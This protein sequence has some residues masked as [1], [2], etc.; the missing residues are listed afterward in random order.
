MK[1]ELLKFLV[2]LL[3]AIGAGPLSAAVYNWSTT[4]ANNATADPA[5]NFSEGMSPSAV[6]DSARALMQQIQ[7]W[8]KDTSG[9]NLQLGGGPVAFTMTSNEGFTSKAVMAGAVLNFYSTVTV[10]NGANPTL[11][12]D[13]LG[14]SPIRINSVD[15]LPA[16]AFQI[17]GHYTATYSAS[18]D[19][20]IVQ[21]YYANSLSVPLGGLIP[22]TGTVVPNANF[23]FPA[24]QCLSTTTY[25]AYWVLRGSPASGSCAGGQ[26]QIID[27]SGRAPV[28]LD[29]MPGFSAANRLT[30]AATGCG[31]AMTSVGSSCANGVEGATV[32]LAELPAITSSGSN[33]IS[34]LSALLLVDATGGLL[35]FNPPGAAGFRTVN[36]T[37][38][39]RQ[40]T[41]TGVN[42]ISVTSSGTTNTVRPQ[43]PPVVGVTYLLRVL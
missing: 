19:A 34:V 5:I 7:F 20:W 42:S 28:G 16:G 17:V 35:D 8:R 31:T 41:S 11:N 37:A 6:N 9:S 33:T 24:G 1:K 38:S 23:V 18:L 30:S 12:V 26:F 13:G 14:A 32:K 3:V 40:Q 2:L 36:N 21:N 15:A 29:T 43:V 22:F 4:A 25:V 39:L 27:L 10:S